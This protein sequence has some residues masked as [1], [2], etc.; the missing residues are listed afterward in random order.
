MS[1]NKEIIER[2]QKE[3]DQNLTNFQTIAKQDE[4][5]KVPSYKLVETAAAIGTEVDL[6]KKMTG[7]YNDVV[8]DNKPRT[9][10]EIT[11]TLIKNRA[12]N[13]AK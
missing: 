10:A 7:E 9:S 4:G 11:A 5:K 6:L 3:L 12:V 8:G 1:F 2:T 13:K